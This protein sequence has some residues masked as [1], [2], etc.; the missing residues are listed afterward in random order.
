ML[1]KDQKDVLDHLGYEWWMF[2]A[3]YELLKNIEKNS[4]PARNALVESLWVH[5]RAL[6]DF[7]YFKPDSGDWGVKTLNLRRSEWK[8]DSEP[9]KT[10]NDWRINTN[11]RVV[12]IT[13]KRQ[14]PLQYE[15]F[16]VVNGVIEQR[17]KEVKTALATDMPVNWIGDN[18]IESAL[19]KIGPRG[20]AGDI[21]PNGEI[22]ATMTNCP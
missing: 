9:T 18:S 3:T 2:R 6:I 14:D 7:F 8:E 20:P 17:I 11:K 1:N 10:L 5:G 12:H 15:S 13:K 21:T 19:I 4:D 22:G 16:P